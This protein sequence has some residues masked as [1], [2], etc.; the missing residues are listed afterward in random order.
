MTEL[1]SGLAEF[2]KLVT[3][4]LCGNF[5]GDIDA[6]VLPP[7]LRTLELQCNWITQTLTFAEHLPVDLLHLGLA[8]NLLTNGNRLSI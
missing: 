3:L 2:T 4:N 1:D 8:R 5:I 6:S 7:G